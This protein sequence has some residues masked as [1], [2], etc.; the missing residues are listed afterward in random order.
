MRRFFYVKFVTKEVSVS[1]LKIDE[2]FALYFFF[3]YFFIFQ[4]IL[5]LP[6]REL[7]NYTE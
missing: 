6:K 1:S 4:G 5:F 2:C 7:V 3:L